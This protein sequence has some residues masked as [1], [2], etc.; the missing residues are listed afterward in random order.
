MESGK[1]KVRGL[2]VRRRDTPRFIYNAQI[3]MI[4]V[5]SL[6]NNSK[7]FMQKI[8]QALD[9]V[10]SYRQKLVNGEVAYL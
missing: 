6:A 7:E 5:F 1:L 8:P 9:V 2:E 3:E 4:N 10:K